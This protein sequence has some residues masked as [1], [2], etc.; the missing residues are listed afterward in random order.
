[1]PPEALAQLERL[2]AGG[3]LTMAELRRV[4]AEPATAAHLR[5]K[6]MLAELAPY[7]LSHHLQVER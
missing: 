6:G 4:C 2:D 5:A 3:G 7:W 1:M